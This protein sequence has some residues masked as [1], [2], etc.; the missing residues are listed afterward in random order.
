[1]AWAAW[2]FRRVDVLLPGYEAA[3]TLTSAGVAPL[4][5]A[6]RVSE[7]LK[8]L[9]HT[10]LRS[11]ETAGL[12]DAADHVHCWT[13]FSANARYMALRTAA[14][15]QYQ[16]NLGIRRACRALVASTLQRAG[17]PAP[18]AG[19]IDAAIGYP[20]AE[21]PFL[22]DSPSLFDVGTSIFAYHRP[23]DLVEQLSTCR[24][25]VVLRSDRQGFVSFT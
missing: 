20:L 16:C 3:Y 5:A 17:N 23:I 18:T 7:E 15:E 22:I 8:R 19:E 13:R 25:S 11:L 2:T 12:A 24:S 4:V 10:A 9:S 1:M 6:R 21:M 14:R